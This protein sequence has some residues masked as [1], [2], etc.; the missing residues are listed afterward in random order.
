VAPAVLTTPLAKLSAEARPN[1]AAGAAAARTQTSPEAATEVTR[2][3]GAPPS[4]TA[5]KPAPAEAATAHK[6]ERAEQRRPTTPEWAAAKLARYEAAALR[7]SQRTAAG[8]PCALADDVDAS[9]FH[10]QGPHL[11]RLAAAPPSPTSL[12]SPASACV[13]PTATR[14]AHKD[15]SPTPT[16]D[17]ALTGSLSSHGPRLCTPAEARTP[18][19]A[20]AHPAAAAATSTAAPA[21]TAAHRAAAAGAPP[22]ESSHAATR[23]IAPPNSREPPPPRAAHATAQLPH[24]P[25]A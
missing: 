13:Q 11:R 20:A 5:T 14:A 25:S 22:S 9:T 16:D 3:R 17:A 7:Q 12:P 10:S 8:R 2:K 18:V 15:A 1:T 24:T 6:R 21:T 19:P 4:W 23:A